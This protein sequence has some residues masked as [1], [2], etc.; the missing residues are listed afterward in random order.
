VGTVMLDRKELPKQAF[1]EKLKVGE[2]L[3]RI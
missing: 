3:S 2:K 1:L